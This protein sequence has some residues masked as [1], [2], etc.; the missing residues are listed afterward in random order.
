MHAYLRDNHSWQSTPTAAQNLPL[1]C[2]SCARDF[3]ARLHPCAMI[4]AG[5]AS[6]TIITPGDAMT[7]TTRL[8]LIGLDSFAGVILPLLLSGFATAA[9][10]TGVPATSASLAAANHSQVAAQADPSSGITD[11]LFVPATIAASAIVAAT[12]GPMDAV[13]AVT[14]AAATAVAVIVAAAT[15]T[16]EPRSTAGRCDCGG[17]D[18][19]FIADDCLQA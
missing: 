11:P 19:P 13:A 17:R 8:L 4:A 18:C 2:Q 12:A 14:A 5:Q 7:F 9:R 3:L 6:S 16:A 15:A 1:C 10:G